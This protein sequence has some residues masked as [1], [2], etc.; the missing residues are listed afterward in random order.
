[1]NYIDIIIVIP[2]LYFFIKGFS[3]G[4]IK[5]ISDL[6]GLV[7]GAYVAV[8]FSSYL[9]PKITEFF[10]QNI[11][12][13]PII[14]FTTLFFVALLVIKLLGYMLETVTKALALGFISKILGAIFGLLKVV[15]FFSFLLFFLTEY[16]I[17]TIDEQ[18]DSVLI[19]PI[20]KTTEII[21]PKVTE[22][23]DIIL[24]TV[25]EQTKKA[26]EEIEKKVNPQEQ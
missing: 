23:K 14:S 10:P 2:L 17:L 15:V 16:N 7:I 21:M 9:H 22:H 8:N 12:L 6:F 18:Q 5:E 3:N 11:D 13:V 24:E 20:K 1:M 19:P 4:L 26:K 25:E